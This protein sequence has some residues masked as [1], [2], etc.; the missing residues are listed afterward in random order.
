[1][2]ELVQSFTD[3][4]G[5]PLVGGRVFTYDAGTNNPR[6]TFTNE[7]GTV[8]NTNPI[9]LDGRGE[10]VIFW[11]GAYKVVLADAAGVP[12]KTVDNIISTDLLVSGAAS[13]VLSQLADTTSP[14]NGAALVGYSPAINYTLGLGAFLNYT[15]GRT[16]SEIAAGT[17]PTNYA[18]FP[19]DPRRYGAAGDWNGTTGT[20]DTAAC[21]R[22]IDSAP[23]G[24][25]VFFLE[26]Y[27]ITDYLT[28]NK[29]LN[30]I[31]CGS[32]S[33][34]N[35]VIRPGLYQTV[36]TT[37][38]IFKLVARVANYAFGSY[39]IIGVTIDGVYAQGPSV[40]SMGHSFVTAD[41][42][43][44]GGDYHVRSVTLKNNVTR[45]F[46]NSVDLTG[47]VYMLNLFNNEVT[48]SNC[49]LRIL[50]GGASVVGGQIRVY[51]DKYT[52]NSSG[53]K[54]FT[55]TFGGDASFYGMTVGDG[56]G[57]GLTFNEEC[58]IYTDPS[59]HF[60]KN[61]SGG[62]YVEI[63][64][65][66]PA[67]S[68]NKIICGKFLDNG[69]GLA[70]PDIYVNKTTT[71]FSGG[72]FF[73]P[74][75]I[76]DCY[77]GSPS[78]LKVDVPVGHS[79]IDSPAFIIGKNACGPS[80][81]QLSASQ[82]S[83]NFLGIWEREFYRTIAYSASMATDALGGTDFTITATNNTAFTI[84]APSNPFPNQRLKY[85]IRNTSGGA[86]GAVTW[87]AVFKMAAWAS[88]ATGF[89]RSITFR[90]NGTNWIEQNR[91]TTDVPN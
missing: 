46:D 61:A 43:V 30:L 75:K 53:P 79:G 16:A 82:V 15:F 88:P 64:Q 56:L 76:D 28:V 54:M 74:M 81:G 29:P 6:A 31:G 35:T 22:A 59:C 84:N 47:I 36:A 70:G 27:R 4:A 62:I 52:L 11:S 26:P 42:T 19:G 69:P 60:E 13:Q 87:N 77:L 17:T 78:G 55:D 89:S 18:F 3:S 58:R 1:M 7:A 10:A 68:A 49:P 25:Q 2:P 85:T 67:T 9:I 51:G 39:G 38:G 91:N 24:G 23:E 21:Q 5:A 14:T 20:D 44:N 57:Y 66:N 86:L 71:A 80:I 12:I 63:T 83:S 72:G 40:G 33:D 48:S 90:Y 8:N 50:Q 41:T 34:Y 37:K 32:S 45:F 65:A 73:W